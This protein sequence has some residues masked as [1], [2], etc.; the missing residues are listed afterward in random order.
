MLTQTSLI[1]LVGT[2]KIVTWAEL[3]FGVYWEIFSLA[4]NF[5]VVD[6]TRFRLGVEPVFLR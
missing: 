6:S 3:V 5:S 2:T 4:V 1:S